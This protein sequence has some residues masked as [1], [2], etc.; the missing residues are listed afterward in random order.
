MGRKSAI[1]QEQLVEL[2]KEMT[3]SNKVYSLVAKEHNLSPSTLYNLFKK[4]NMG[5]I[6][7]KRGRPAGAVKQDKAKKVE[8]EA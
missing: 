3:E 7:G 1:S 6:A 4:N 8:V 5:I 2:H